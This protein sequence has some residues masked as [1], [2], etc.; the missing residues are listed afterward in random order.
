LGPRPYCG[1][2]RPHSRPRAPSGAHRP[3]HRRPGPNLL[4]ATLGIL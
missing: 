4:T 3:R 2:D 1:S